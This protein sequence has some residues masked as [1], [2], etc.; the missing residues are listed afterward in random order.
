MFKYDDTFYILLEDTIYNIRIL[1]CYK[2]TC[3]M[4]LNKNATESVFMS[5]IELAGLKKAYED[6]VKQR[7]IKELLNE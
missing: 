4:L 5:Y 3:M 6:L 7:L 1:E 2:D